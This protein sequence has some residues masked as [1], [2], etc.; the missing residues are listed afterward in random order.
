MKM[1]VNQ[2]ADI[3][4]VEYVV[5]SSFIKL[6]EVKGLA[7]AVGKQKPKNTTGRG[8]PST[9]YDI[10]QVVEIKIHELTE[11]V[12]EA[13]VLTIVA[14]QDEAEVSPVVINDS[15]F[16]P[17]IVTEQMPMT[18]ETLVYQDA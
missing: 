7:T 5:A 9:I 13:P 18:D 14:P 4:G 17:V 11:S 16:E 3:L 2:L 12:F 10:P 15:D 8:K 1:T 6:L